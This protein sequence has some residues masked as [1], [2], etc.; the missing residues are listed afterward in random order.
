MSDINFAEVVARVK[1]AHGWKGTDL[2][3]ALDVDPSSVSNWSRGRWAPNDEAAKKLLEMYSEIPPEAPEVLDDI[4]KKYC[5]EDEKTVV[6][7]TADHVFKIDD[8]EPTAIERLNP[9]DLSEIN[10]RPIENGYAKFLENLRYFM[11]DS[12]WNTDEK[13]ESF[14]GV[15]PGYIS[16]FGSH[17]D[18]FEEL[19]V[20]DSICNNLG[21]PWSVLA[22][23]NV[24]KEDAYARTTFQLQKME[25]EMQALR[26]KAYTLGSEL[27]YISESNSEIPNP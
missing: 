1:K 3:K 20:I 15:E 22:F 25:E 19:I 21:V 18:R 11:K 8:L 26:V 2:A 9:T 7:V 27:G 23:S 12:R 14:L 6:E 13:L 16:K 4:V 5:E 10:Q 24:A 17:G